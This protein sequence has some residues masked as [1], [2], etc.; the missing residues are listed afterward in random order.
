MSSADPRPRAERP[1]C[2]H[3]S[4]CRKCGDPNYCGA[5]AQYSYPA[6]GGGTA[7]LCEEHA[8]RLLPEAELINMTRIDE[9]RDA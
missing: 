8:A 4:F 9:V 3:A 2:G 5:P 1:T 6:M 7:Y